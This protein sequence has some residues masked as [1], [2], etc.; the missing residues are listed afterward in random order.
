MMIDRTLFLKLITCVLIGMIWVSQRAPASQLNDAPK[1]IVSLSPAATEWIYALRLGDRLAGVTEQCDFPLGAM[2]A[3]K[4]GAFMNVSVE[5][6]LALNA[7][8]VVS[9]HRLPAILKNKLERA[10]IRV[11]VFAPSRLA[12]F[13]LEIQRLGARLNARRRGTELAH[14]FSKSLGLEQLKQVPNRAAGKSSLIFVSAQPVFVVASRTWMSDLFELA[15]YSNSFSAAE[16]SA[17]FPR[18]SVESLARI[19]ADHWFVFSDASR[20]KHELLS[21]YERLTKQLGKVA[22]KHRLVVLP[23]DIFQRP[24]PR[25]KEAYRWLQKELK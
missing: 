5:R 10:R 2:A 18:V 3:P 20:N 12:D 8:D 11:H 7:T 23:A 6:I 14:E 21:P 22:S 1:K 17:A 25:L 15:G 4:V 19:Q 24:G 9:T 13:P 16:G